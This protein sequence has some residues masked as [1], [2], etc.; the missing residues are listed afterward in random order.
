MSNQGVA[1][2]DKLLFIYLI[3]LWE[4]NITI[5]RCGNIS[6]A[7]NGEHAD[8]SANGVDNDIAIELLEKK[9]GNE[10]NVVAIKK[11]NGVLSL[12]HNHL[13]TLC[14]VNVSVLESISLNSVSLGSECIEIDDDLLDAGIDFNV[15]ILNQFHILLICRPIMLLLRALKL[16]SCVNVGEQSN[17]RNLLK[18]SIIV[19]VPILGLEVQTALHRFIPEYPEINVELE[20]KFR[21][22]WQRTP[23]SVRVQDLCKEMN[24]SRSYVYE[25]WTRHIIPDDLQ[26]FGKGVKYRQNP[27]TAKVE[28]QALTNMDGRYRAV[29][30]FRPYDEHNRLRPEVICLEVPGE[31]IKV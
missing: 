3:L 12:Q 4:Y 22:G 14:Q 2:N 30:F 5:I 10:N 16:L 24:D 6:D 25:T 31:I 27:F 28:S 29:L 17:S 11:E 1:N 7:I 13:E 9:R 18:G 20:K 15:R 21:G 8:I 19:V 23:F 26:C